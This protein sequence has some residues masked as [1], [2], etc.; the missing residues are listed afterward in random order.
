MKRNVYLV[1]VNN[2][3]GRN[4]FLP[5]SVGLLQAY[6]QREEE[7][8]TSYRFQEALWWREPPERVV[9]RMHGAPPDVLGVSCYIWNWEYSK[10]LSKAVKLAYP[11]CLVVAGGPHVPEDV[12]VGFF[13]DH[14]YFD[15][16]VHH[17]GELPFTLILKGRLAGD[18]T[19]RVPGTTCR[20]RNGTASSMPAVG[21]TD[22][23][24]IPSPYLTGVFDELIREPDVDWDASQE[25]HRGCP[26]ACTFC[27]WGS[28]VFT[29]VRRF[30]EDRI[31]A[32]YEW[33]AAHGIGL[34]YNCDANYGLFPR[35]LE[36]TERLVASKQQHGHPQQ[37][38][39]AYAKNSNQRVFEI[40]KILNDAGMCKGVTLSFQSLD[41]HTLQLIKRK[42]MDIN[43]FSGM[44]A[45]YKEAGI[46]TY[47]ELIL[48]LPGETYDSFCDGVDTLLDAGQHDALNIYPCMILPNSEMAQPGY[49]E[50]HGIQSVQVPDLGDHTIPAIDAYQETKRLVVATATMPLEDWRRAYVF[51]L[52]VQGFHSMGLTQYAAITARVFGVAYS[53]FYERLAAQIPEAACK[54]GESADRLIGGEPLTE[55]LPLFG[56]NTWTPEESLFLTWI[57][58]DRQRA[59]LRSELCNLMVDLLRNSTNDPE[60][61]ARDVMLF[62]DAIVANPRSP[63][64]QEVS[65]CYDLPG[66]F[67]TNDVDY[68]LHEGP[69]RF[70]FTHPSDYGGDYEDYA[71]EVVWYGRKASRWRA[72]V[73]RL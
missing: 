49:S 67:G 39:A 65:L 63:R 15:V 44:V 47:T 35:D 29:K 61:L 23:E 34:L 21:R 41:P 60:G 64:R 24:G 4:A 58:D 9:S 42:N 36:L 19:P 31:Y 56:P 17:E 69:G 10:A 16:L 32:E 40:G 26:Y 5:Y 71:R 51:G 73:A 33:M 30:P 3:Y 55:V 1:Q 59:K 46:P 45:S 50:L 38:R 11:D 8:R 57:N 22:V 70:E 72:D 12:P 48:P 18:D 2:R 28:A 25:T 62:Q 6:A 27:D 68:L 52:I 7:I 20:N 13:Q 43:D 66:F 54:A 53:Q 37:F 14:P